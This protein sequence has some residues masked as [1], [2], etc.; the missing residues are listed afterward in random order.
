MSKPIPVVCGR[1]KVLPVVS[2][3]A[4]AE[5]GEPTRGMCPHCTE[6]IWIAPRSAAHIESG[7]VKPICVECA[8]ELYPDA[9]HIPIPEAM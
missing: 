8:E 3:E 6:A 4:I 1:V 7:A 9:F 2:P 5:H